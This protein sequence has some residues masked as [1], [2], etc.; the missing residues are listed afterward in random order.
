MEIQIKNMEE[1]LNTENTLGLSDV[2][3]SLTDILLDLFLD[4]YEMG[5]VARDISQNEYVDN[6]IRL[7][8][9]AT[10]EINRLK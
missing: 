1:N 8:K 7:I 10:Q 6:K 4:A 9:R 5:I 3:R 2:S